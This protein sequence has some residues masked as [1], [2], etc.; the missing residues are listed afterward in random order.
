MKKQDLHLT[1]KDDGRGFELS[2]KKNGSGL[3]NTK[4]KTELYKGTVKINS[5]PVRAAS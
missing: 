1:T 4:T 3:N 5:V 2:Q